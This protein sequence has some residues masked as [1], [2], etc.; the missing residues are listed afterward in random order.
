MRNHGSILVGVDGSAGSIA[1]LGWAARAAAVHRAPLRLV[2]M[3]DPTADYGPGATEPLTSTDYTRLEDHGRWILDTCAHDAKQ[4]V[5]TVDLTPI[6]IG[7]EL[8]FGASGPA[9]VD[10]SA[11]C[12][13][14]VVGSRE[15][16]SMRRALLGSV[17]AMLARR[18]LCP[19]VVVRDGVRG[20]ATKDPIVV[21]VDGTQISEP[22]IEAALIEASARGVALLAMHASSESDLTEP[23]GDRAIGTMVL[24]ESLAGWQ[25]RFPEVEIRREIV[26][27]RPVHRLL[28]CSEH[29][30]LLVVGSRGRGGFASM[31]FGSTSQAVLL[32]AQCPIMVLR[33]TG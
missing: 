20:S 30:Q 3:V 15:R 31:L 4:I 24:A 10:R 33:D 25:E 21:G 18:A 26:Y 27:D 11:Q 12:R 29:A 28:E 17:S 16:G 14:L 5:D 22:A 2:H 32:S 13:A 7:T 23:Q 9:L 1:A 8:V 19:V 6:E